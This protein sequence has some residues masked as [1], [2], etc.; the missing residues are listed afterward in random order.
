MRMM[1]RIEPVEEHKE[2]ALVPGEPEK[3]TRIGSRLNLQMETLTIEFLRKNTDMFALSPSSFK[4]IDPE[5]IVHMLNADPQ[6]KPVKQKK[7]SFGMERNKI[8]KEEVNKLLKAGYV[9]MYNTE[10]LSNVV[11]VPATVGKWRMCTNFTDLNKAYP[12]DPY[13]LPQI[14][15]LVDS[16]AGCALFSMMDAYQGYHQIFMTEEDRDK[17]SFITDNG[18]YCYNVYVDDM[19]IKSKEGEDYLTH[20]QASFEVMRR[21]DMKLNPAKCIFGMG[22]PKTIKD[23]QKL[24]GKVASLARFISRSADR[25]LPFF[26]ILRKVKDFQWIA[27]CEQALKDLKE[28]LLLANPEV[29]KTLYLYLAVSDN[30]VSSAL[31]REEAGHQSLIYYVSKKL[32]DAEKKYI[33]IEKLALALVTTSMKLR[34]Y[35]NHTK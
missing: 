33:Q 16:T 23:V 30:A 15:L 8:I 25:N 31:V 7:M 19:L 12:K 1:E 21:Y 27:E 24:T 13:P 4:G 22:S 10:W 34:P 11:V 18:I 5:V 14:D 17:T 9:A 32:Q 26:K 20:L 6:A 35:S 3:T 29:G 2:I 28:Y